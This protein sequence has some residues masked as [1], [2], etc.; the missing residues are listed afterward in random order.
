MDGLLRSR[1]LTKRGGGVWTKRR[2]TL[3]LFLQRIWQIMRGD[4]TESLT[5]DK[6]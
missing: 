1:Y 6:P 4:G 5:L 3:P 2:V